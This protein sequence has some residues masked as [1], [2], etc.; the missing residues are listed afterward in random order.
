MD[1]W[2]KDL[3][4]DSRPQTNGQSWLPYN[5]SFCFLREELIRPWNS[6]W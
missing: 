2:S 5:A 1:S 6:R 3:C 4:P